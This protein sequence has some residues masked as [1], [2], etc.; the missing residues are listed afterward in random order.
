MR[1]LILLF[2]FIICTAAVFSQGYE[3]EWPHGSEVTLI[4]EPDEGFEI[5]NWTENGEVVSTD[6]IY[7]FTVT[8]PRNLIANF[9]R[10]T[11][12]INV[13]VQPEIGGEVTGDG[14][15]P[16]GELVVLHGIPADGYIFEGWEGI[17]GDLIPHNPYRFRADNDYQVTG[18]FRFQ[19][20]A[21]WAP[22]YWVILGAGIV[23]IFIVFLIRRK[24]DV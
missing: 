4:A 9:A 24:K 11:Y 2:V 12:I 1:K 23:L 3:E 21:I 18:V 22:S 13:T 7:T 16:N 6:P 10:K 8:G 20:A 14:E 19:P 5:V 15:Y 17:T